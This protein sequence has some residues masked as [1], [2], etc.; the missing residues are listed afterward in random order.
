MESHFTHVHETPPPGA[1]PDWTTAQ[2]WDAFTADDPRLWDRLFARQS[3]MLPGRASGEFLRGNHVLRLAKPG[4]HDYRH[5]NARLMDAT[6]TRV[7]DVD[8]KSVV[9][10]KDVSV[11]VE[12]RTRLDNNK[13]NQK[14]SL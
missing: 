5:H 2:D 7:V 1:A 8:R 6:G 9:Y 3:A 10:G 13:K 11:L 4:L 12:T 14:T